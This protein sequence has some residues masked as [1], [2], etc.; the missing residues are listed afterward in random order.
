VPGVAP[1]IEPGKRCI[2]AGR[3]GSGKTTLAG[4]FLARSTQHWVILNPKHTSTYRQLPDAV[5]HRK[6]AP[7]SIIS[8]AS[9]RK[10][11]VLEL[12]GDEADSNY[13]DGIIGWLHGALHNIGLCCDELYTLHTSGGR[14][15]P[16][17]IGWLTRG[18]EYR[19][20]FLGLTQRPAWLSR[21]LFS[22]TDYLCEMELTLPEDRDRL[23]EATGDKHFLERVTGHRWLCYD[24]Q[25]NAT[26]LFGPVPSTTLKESRYG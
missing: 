9:R 26:T 13:M 19:Q 15:G 18:R 25:R 22:E 8:D 20:S 23:Y 6:F 11:T 14:A 21:F 10:F 4:W 5:V 2:V 12:S 1:R 7:R 16:G 24:V 17:L 3:T